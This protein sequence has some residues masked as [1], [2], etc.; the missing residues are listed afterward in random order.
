MDEGNISESAIEARATIAQVFDDLRSAAVSDAGSK[1]F[2]NGVELID[3]SVSIGP[4]DKPLLGVK[5]KIAGPRPPAASPV[6]QGP[7]TNASS[8]GGR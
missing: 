6:S 5:A 3:I 7:E 2:P 4:A 8:I 1:L